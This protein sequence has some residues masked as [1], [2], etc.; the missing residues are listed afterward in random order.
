MTRAPH[1]LDF[2]IGEA[3]CATTCSALRVRGYNA[4]RNIQ[5]TLSGSGYLCVPAVPHETY[6]ELVARVAS[7]ATLPAT[8]VERTILGLTRLP[9]QGCF[10]VWVINEL[11]N[12]GKAMI[13]LDALDSEL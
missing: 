6:G 11:A 7:V 12:V 4:A 3:R 1:S 5:R 10:L 13:P 9:K 8:L 2:A